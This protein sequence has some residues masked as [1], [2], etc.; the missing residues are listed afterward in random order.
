MTIYVMNALI[1]PIDFERYPKALVKIRKASVEEVR[2]LLSNENFVSAVGHE[3]TAAL[4]TQL[5]GVKIPYNR[6]TV[7][8]GPG[9][10]CAHFVLKTRIPE[11]KVLTLEELKELA[12]D[13]AISEIE[14]VTEK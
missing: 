11:G 12:F 1:I 2:R 3:A 4:L 8:L 10:I 7:K 13:L 6:I 9:D 14:E 5:L